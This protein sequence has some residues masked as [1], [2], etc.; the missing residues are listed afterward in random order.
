[1]SQEI[2]SVLEHSVEVDVSLAFA[3]NYRT[4]ITTWEDP[5]AR[6]SLDGPFADGSWGTTSIPDHP[7]IRWQIRDVRPGRSFIV[8]MPLDPAAVLSFEW[9]FEAISANRTRMTQRIVLSGDN[10]AAYESI[11][12]ARFESTL[13]DGMK[14]IAEVMASSSPGAMTD[15]RLP[16]V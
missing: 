1:V 7:L 10:G 14:R 5:P 4:D 16:T 6:F 2:P 9:R 13:A 15:P 3:W 8:E 11:I 12:R